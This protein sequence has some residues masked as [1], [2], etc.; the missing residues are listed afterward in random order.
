MKRKKQGRRREYD[1]FD[2]EEY[3]NEVLYEEGYRPPERRKRK[4]RGLL[5][6]MLTFLLG[7]VIFVFAFLLLFHIQK[8]EVTGN[9]YSTEEEVIKWLKSDKYAMNSIYAWWKYDDKRIEELPVVESCKITIKSP[10]SIKITVKEKEIG[11]YIECNDRYVYFDKDG[12]AVL[13][14][15]TKIEQAVFIE[16]MSVDASKVKVGK[17]LPV[18]DKDVFKRIV[19]ASQ[20]LAKYELSPD[21][22]ACVDSELDLYFGNVEVLLGKTSYDERVAQ[23]S[24]ILK[25]L[26]EQYPDIQGTLH[27]EN[28]Q[29]ADKSIRFVPGE[30]P[31]TGSSQSEADISGNQAGEETQTET[32]TE[33]GDTS[34]ETAETQ[35]ESQG[36]EIE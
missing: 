6:G 10:W 26:A 33:T 15:T 16:G 11:G 5:L 20:L 36:V 29:A 35:P 24:P 3:V 25:K 17:V 23:I 34:T 7:I 8:I 19:E 1:G 22:V 28:Y 12:I 21:R 18:S 14:T 13:S 31:K 32:Q 4:R 2:D 9:T 30:T 27:L